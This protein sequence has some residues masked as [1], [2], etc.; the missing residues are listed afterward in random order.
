MP[1]NGVRILPELGAS[2]AILTLA[3]RPIWLRASD[4][5]IDEEAVTTALLTRCKQLV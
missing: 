3:L 4:L 1:P 2:F 5:L